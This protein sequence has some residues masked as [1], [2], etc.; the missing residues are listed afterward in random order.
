MFNESEIDYMKVIL[1]EKSIENRDICLYTLA[2]PKDKEVLQLLCTSLDITEVFTTNVDK[3]D[4]DLVLDTE[5]LT[6]DLT[7]IEIALNEPIFLYNME[8]FLSQHFTITTKKKANL[9]CSIDSRFLSKLPTKLLKDKNFI[10]PLCDDPK[11]YIRN[12]F[13]IM[14][15]SGYAIHLLDKLLNSYNDDFDIAFAC[16]KADPTNFI[17]LSPTLKQSKILVLEAVKK[18]PS[19]IEYVGKKFQDDFDVAIEAYS[20]DPEEATPFLSPRLKIMF[21]WG[22]HSRE[23]AKG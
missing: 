9:I 19:L 4:D 5:E 6:W 13:N 8:W 18:N 16:V 20:E 11:I 2:T 3:Y 21:Y 15:D 1:F 17:F 22:I 12:D 7:P 23:R 14:S 10:L